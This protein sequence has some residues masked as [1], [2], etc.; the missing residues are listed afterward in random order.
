MKLLLGITLVIA[1]YIIE[2]M[3]RP[4]LTKDMVEKYWRENEQNKKG[5]DAYDPKIKIGRSKKDTQSSLVG[6]SSFSRSTEF[7]E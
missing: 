7:W 1:A 3:K 6:S 5:G 2:Q 4:H